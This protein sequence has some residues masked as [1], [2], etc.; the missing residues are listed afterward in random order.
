NPPATSREGGV[1]RAGFDRQVDELRQLAFHGQEWLLEFER[2]ERERTGIKSLKVGFNRVFGYYLE[3]TRANADLVP[4]HYVRKQTLV[5]A[6]RYITDEL[7]AYED[8]ILGA[9]ERLCALE[10]ELFLAL[11]AEMEKALPRVQ[12]LAA[13]LA[14]VDVLA[15]LAECAHRYDYVRPVVDNGDRILIRGGR[16]Q[17]VERC[18]HNEAFVPN[19]VRLDGREHRHAIITGPNMGGK[20]TYMRQVALIVVMAQMGSF[21]PAREAVVGCVDQVFA[22]VGAADDLAGGQSTFMVEM[23]EVAGIL[24]RATRRSLVILDEIGRGTSTFDGMS[25]A[26]AV[27]EYLCRRI[28]AKTLLATHYHELTSLGDEIPGV[29]NLSVSVKETAG[30][31]VFLKRVLPGRADKSYGIHVAALA[32]LPGEVVRRAE[33]VLEGLEQQSAVRPA[34][35]AVAQP[36]LFAEEEHPLLTQLRSMKLDEMRPVE[37]LNTLHQWQLL[38]LPERSRRARAR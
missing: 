33:Q 10:H 28:G 29:I 25:I 16:H 11:R 36:S 3:V 24:A 4:P 15:A 20:S 2:R 18:L 13:A 1:I 6:E 27:M 5:N 23:V 7:K 21:V 31:V 26:R 35:R 30:G 37:A 32:G 17:V 22:R 19:D 12:T 8:R 34:P 38:L 9:R 14:R